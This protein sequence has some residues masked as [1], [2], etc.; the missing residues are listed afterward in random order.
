MVLEKIYRFSFQELSWFLNIRIGFH[1][2]IDPGLWASDI[3]GPKNFWVFFTPQKFEQRPETKRIQS[4]GALHFGARNFWWYPFLQWAQ[5][6]IA[7]RGE[8]FK[9]VVYL[10]YTTKIWERLK[11]W[12]RHLKF[13]LV[14]HYHSNF[15][16]LPFVKLKKKW[17]KIFLKSS[18]NNNFFIISSNF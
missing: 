13:A 3:S 1:G 15:W 6:L 8:I 2:Q 14:F 5:N 11:L 17:V 12:N 7:G 9:S 10:P 16:Y 18:S 4:R